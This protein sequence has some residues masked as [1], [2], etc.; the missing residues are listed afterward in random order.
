MDKGFRNIRD[1]ASSFDDALGRLGKGGVD[2]SARIAVQIYNGGMMGA[3]GGIYYLG[4]PTTFNGPEVEGAGYTPVVDTTTS[5][6][7][8]V[9]DGT[10]SVGD[11]LVATAV[12][13]RWVAEQ[14][15]SGSPPTGVTCG[16]CT[17]PDG[18]LTLSWVFTDPPAVS[19]GTGTT[20]LTQSGPTWYSPV[21]S[22]LSTSGTAYVAYT[23]FCAGGV[24]QLRIWG[25]S[26]SLPV[27]ASI[28]NGWTLQFST[29]FGDFGSGAGGA[30]QLSF[31]CSP[32]DWT[33]GAN[34]IGSGFEFQWT[35]TL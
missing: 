26:S 25:A 23:V 19:G 13:G 21:T 6:A 32:L 14:G 17:I 1:R 27:P 35:I 3:G 18:T 12:G 34:F 10:P 15:G 9:L 20:T 5:V 8:D 30:E 4:N 7:V 29:W 33:V 11:I 31:V 24:W 16:A 28:L 2:G 22:Y